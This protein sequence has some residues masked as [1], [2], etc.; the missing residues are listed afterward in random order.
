MD[1]EVL[2]SVFYII[3]LKDLKIKFVLLLPF[4]FCAATVTLL[5]AKS[6]RF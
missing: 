3:C 6:L 4:S 5:T 1:V 2:N